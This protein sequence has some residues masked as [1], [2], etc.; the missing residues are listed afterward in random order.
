MAQEGFALS[1]IKD[2]RVYRSK[3]EGSYPSD[4][5]NKKLCVIIHRIVMKL[6]E[7]G[8]SLGEFDHLYL[9]LTT[10]LNEGTVGVRPVDPYHKWYRYIDVGISEELYA[11]LE[12]DSCIGRVVEILQAVLLELY[13]AQNSVIGSSF[14][15]ALSQGENMRMLFK[16]KQSAKRKAE[17]YL[18]YGDDG[19][20]V[21]LLCVFDEEGNEIMRKDLPRTIDLSIMGEIQLSSKKVTIKPRKDRS[22]QHLSPISFEL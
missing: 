19:Y 7:H 20:Y 9:V 12:T 1:V 22:A 15:E 2:I 16:S 8:F 10:Y 14:A 11:S 13:A 5:M 3:I 18:R 6:R 21:P 4:L 17:V